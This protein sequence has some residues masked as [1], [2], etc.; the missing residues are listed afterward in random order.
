MQKINECSKAE[1]TLV[2]NSGESTANKLPTALQFSIGANK[3]GQCLHDRG[4]S[5]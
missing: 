4:S 5:V 1:S 3:I 2:K